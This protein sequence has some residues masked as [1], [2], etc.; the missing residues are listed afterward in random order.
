MNKTCLFLL[1][2]LLLGACR[3]HEDRARVYTL[4]QPY[5]NNH[6]TH[7]PQHRNDVYRSPYDTQNRTYLER[8]ANPRPVPV[9][10][11]QGTPQ[12]EPQMLGH[13]AR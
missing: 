8:Y 10:A 11:W 2:P 5:Y 7:R 6:P 9:G 12:H 4:P 3:H 13:A 1:V